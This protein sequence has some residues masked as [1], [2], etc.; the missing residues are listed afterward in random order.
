MT[1][2]R[3][4]LALPLLLTVL[5]A[6]AQ[7]LLIQ[8]QAVV[9]TAPV[10]HGAD[11]ADDP[12]VWLHP[13]DPARSMILGTD[14]QGGLISYDMDGRQLQIVS[15][16]SKPDN[17]DVL[18]GVTLGGR[19]F[20]LAVAACRSS[21]GHEGLKFWAINPATRQMADVTPNNFVPTF[22]NAQPYGSGVY[23]SKKTG[24]NYAFATN[25][26]GAVEQFELGDGGTKISAKKVRSLKCSGTVEGMVNDDEAGII[27]VSEEQKGI[28]AFPA[29]P[30]GGK[31]GK[32]VIRAGEHGLTPDV[33]G[34]T[35]Y[36]AAG[37][38]GYIIVS[39]Q[40]S[41]NFKIY[42]RDGDHAFVG[43]IDP[44]EGK[45]DDVNDTDGITVTNRPTSKT[46]SK[47]CF[48]VQD[49]TGPNGKHQNFKVYRWED[50]AGDKLLI[51]TTAGDPRK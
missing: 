33:E 20:D 29:E 35:L 22:G 28:W 46:L 1:R 26:A 3:L 11:A 38:K 40:G 44:K 45:I 14:K 37:G 49:G 30:D 21:P 13:T 2:R 31:E 5:P 51:D 23:H 4:A 27:Y 36:T 10:P 12:A 19:K 39:S 6:A 8:P 47:G 32:L 48:I 34:V 7:D 16:N 9:Q 24:K 25:R 43:T 42:N 17:V 50:I 41:N 15:E 18:Y